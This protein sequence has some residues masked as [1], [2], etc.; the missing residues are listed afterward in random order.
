MIWL[1][2]V[3]YTHLGGFLL[4]AAGLVK[5]GFFQ[6]QLALGGFPLLFHLALSVRLLLFHPAQVGLLFLF[7]G[8]ALALQL[9]PALPGFFL[10][11]GAGGFQVRQRLFLSLIHI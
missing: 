10:A 7:E 4:G 3:S 11:F 2:S 1:K 6:F 5:A 8:A 9:F